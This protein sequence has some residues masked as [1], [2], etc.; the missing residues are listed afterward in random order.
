MI[1]PED[2]ELTTT[3]LFEDSLSNLKAQQYILRLYIAGTTLQSVTALQNIK[4]ICEEN[5]QGR[6][7]LEVIDIYQQA[8]ALISENIVAVPTLIK[9]LPLP[10]QRMIGNLS[11]TEKV[12]IGLDILPKGSLGITGEE[13]NGKLSSLS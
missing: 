8:E 4:K 10:L 13:D 12:L 5:L 3:E 6:Y 2:L 9:E 1:D 11:N 7:E